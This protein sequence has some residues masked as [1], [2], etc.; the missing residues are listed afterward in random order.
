MPELHLGAMLGITSHSPNPKVE[1]STQFVLNTCYNY[2]SQTAFVV[3]MR[4][5]FFIELCK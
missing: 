2:S 1:L 4:A 3:M 5:V